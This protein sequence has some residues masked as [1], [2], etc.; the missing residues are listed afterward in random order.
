VRKQGQRSPQEVARARRGA[1]PDSLVVNKASP[2]GAKQPLNQGSPHL[3][4]A[5][6][7]ARKEGRTEGRTQG[8]KEGQTGI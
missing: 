4:E 7:D 5:R 6:K 1:Y 8:R 2:E 3:K